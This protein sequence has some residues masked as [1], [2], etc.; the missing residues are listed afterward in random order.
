MQYDDFIG[1][2]DIIYKKYL[3]FKDKK[4][5]DDNILIILEEI[6]GDKVNIKITVSPNI[7]IREV[8]IIIF[9]IYFS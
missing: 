8:S 1:L 2:L 6:Y 7:N 3:N 4:F 9:I 5:T